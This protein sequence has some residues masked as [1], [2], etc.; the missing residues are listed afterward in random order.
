MFKKLLYINLLSITILSLFNYIVF[1][2]MNSKAY[3]ESFKAY[4][5]RITNMAFQNIDQQIVEAAMEIPQLYFSDISQN[6][7]IL[8]P[9]EEQILGSPVH[10]RELVNH[11]DG[12]RKVYPY[13][14]S[15][16][17]YYEGTK[18]VVTGFTAVHQAE[19]E[20]GIRKY[21][22]WYDTFTASGKDTLFIGNSQGFYPVN[23]P[24]ISYVKKIAL[25][26]W[27]GR[28][29]LLAVHIS[30]DSFHS[31]IDEENGTLVLAGPA[32]EILYVSSENQR[33]V[34]ETVL[35]E[36]EERAEAG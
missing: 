29:I 19:S 22:P 14:K 32:G 11:L 13:V 9:Q 10:I 31:L 17:I 6:E 15:L 28:G 7:D 4:N 33:Q 12:L 24:V 20:D 1:H 36:L 5:Q 16:D 8:R 30:S 18:T 23:E 3:L 34:S 2:N 27:K 25:P 26:K 35:K 21:L